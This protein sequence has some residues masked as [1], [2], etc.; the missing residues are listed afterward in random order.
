MKFNKK[1]VMILIFT[2]IVL[3]SSIFIFYLKDKSENTETNNSKVSKLKEYF[4][5][6]ST[7]KIFL[8]ENVSD[9]DKNELLDKL[10]KLNYFQEVVY[11]SKKDAYKQLNELY[12]IDSPVAQYSNNSNF[13]FGME[14]YI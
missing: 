8:K 1:K 11:I 7:V 14:R 3:I 6:Y 10:K 5:K 2:L 4:E 13:V 12:G 9:I